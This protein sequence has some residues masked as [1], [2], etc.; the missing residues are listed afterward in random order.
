MICRR[1]S[2]H[3]VPRP[4]PPPL[5]VVKLYLFISLPVCRRSTILLL[6]GGGWGGGG[7]G[8]ESFI[9]GRIIRSQGSL[10]FYKAFNSLCPKGM[11]H[12]HF[13]IIAV[14]WI[15]RWWWVIVILYVVL[16]SCRKNCTLEFKEIFSQLRQKTNSKTNQVVDIRY[17]LL[18]Q[19]LL[20]NYNISSLLCIIFKGTV[21]WHGSRECEKIKKKL[22][23]IKKY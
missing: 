14:K 5:P 7:R 13:W 15:I 2:F 10:G 16:L 6:R 18:T 21:K 17:H 11:F 22:N 3:A 1:P 8:A 20:L 12:F 9:H 23:A 19:G 4:P